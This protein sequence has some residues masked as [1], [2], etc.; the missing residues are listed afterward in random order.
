L[1]IPAKMADGSYWQNNRQSVA[2]ELIN[3]A[4][5]FIPDLSNHI[6]VRETATP[7]TLKRY[8]LNKNGSSY[9][10]N[11]TPAQLDRNVMPPNTFIEGLYL[12]GHWVTS[13]AGPG[14][15][16]SVAFSGKKTAE[17]IIKNFI[18]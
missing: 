15:V 8:T 18:K 12:T 6:V 10:W 16:S 5:K 9:G 4:E 7:L 3:R 14:G 13:G 17:L 2:D 1:V 11:A